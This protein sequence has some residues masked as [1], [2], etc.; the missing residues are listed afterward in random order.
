MDNTEK[1]K[2]GDHDVLVKVTM[3]GINPIDNLVVSGELPKIEPVPH[4]PG[5]ESTGIVEEIG[6]HVSDNQ[7]KKGDRVVLHNKVFD[8]TCDMCLNGLD[9]ICRNGGLIGIITNGG[10]AEYVALPARNVFKI[11]DDLDWDMAASL[12]V[13]SLTPYH[14]LKEASLRINEH[15]LVFGASGNTGMIAV[16][17]GKKMGATVIAVSK[18]NWIKDFGADY[19]IS[20]YP[21]IIDQVKE[22]T[23]GRMADVVLNS[24]GVETWDNSLACVGI[25]GRWVT[26]G[27]LTGADVKLNIRSLYTRQIKLIG[28]TGGTRKEMYDLISN[29]Q[30]LKVKVWKRFRLDNVKEALQSLFAKGRDGRIILEVA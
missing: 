28:S 6:L 25:N 21:N 5:A 17:L 16:Q 10:F 30:Q 1:P 18:N 4:I 11:S 2:I 9:M 3:A 13:T 27:G 19:V 15:L 26:F 7:I 8:G 14:A 23:Q 22:I 29:S 20:D 12:P 24:L